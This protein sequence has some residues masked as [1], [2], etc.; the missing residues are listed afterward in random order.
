MSPR[1]LA[2]ARRVYV[3]RRRAEQAVGAD[4]PPA[5][6]LK[7]RN[8]GGRSTAAFGF[9]RGWNVTVRSTSSTILLALVSACALTIFVTDVWLTLRDSRYSRLI[10]DYE[11]GYYGKPCEP[12]LNGDGQK[13][14]IEIK[15][16]GDALAQLP[17]ELTD[18]KQELI[19]LNAFS[20]DNTLRTHVALRSEA[21]KAR[22]LIWEGTQTQRQPRTP[23]AVVYA[24]EGARLSEVQA[25]AIDRAIFT[26]MAARDDSGTWFRWAIFRALIWPVRLVYILLLIAAAILYYKRR[27]AEHRL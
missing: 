4:R 16:R 19:Q 27:R 1:N 9:F 22:I 17:P 11:C 10:E 15:Y 26:A 2:I 13:G 21:G 23:V 6:L 18:E 3:Y 14:R 20:L 5:S 12:D 8:S 7:V 25:S 24:F